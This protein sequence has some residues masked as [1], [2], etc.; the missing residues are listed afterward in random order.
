MQ[1]QQDESTYKLLKLID[2]KAHHSQRELS[3]ALGVSVGK[4]N[5]CLRALKEK[6]WVKVKNFQRNPDKRSYLYILTPSGAEEKVRVTFRFLKRKL[7]EYEVI[8]KE[9]EELKREV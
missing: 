6:G 9:I 8:K 4:V 7:N 2:G 5:Y 3:E 1:M